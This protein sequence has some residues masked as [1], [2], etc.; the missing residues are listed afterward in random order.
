MDAVEGL[1]A[2]YLTQ[3]GKV[4][5]SPQYDI[6][7]STEER[8]GGSCPDFV[9]LDMS[10]REIVIVEVTSSGSLS[11]L[12]ERVTARNARWYLPIRR[13]LDEDGIIAPDWKI[14][15]LGFVREDFT[16]AANTK[17]ADHHDVYFVGLEKA[18]FSFAYWK[19]RETGLPR[20]PPV[21][22]ISGT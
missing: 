18:A 10:K 7:Y 9:A 21:P 8:D 14:R 2:L 15:F 4:F 17:Y 20:R 13:R 5:I 11:S 22:S 3:G 19:E 6:A 1:V 12:Y 16:K